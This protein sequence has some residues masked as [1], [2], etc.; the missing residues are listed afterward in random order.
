V[1]S[2]LQSVITVSDSH[3]C[4]IYG[5]PLCYLHDESGNRM[6]DG[7]SPAASM[8]PSDWLCMGMWHRGG[9]GH[10]RA[11]ACVGFGLA[12]KGGI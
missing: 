1:T 5:A 11:W 10:Q 4:S 12:W 9:G 2:W 6:F 3:W 8:M 7:C